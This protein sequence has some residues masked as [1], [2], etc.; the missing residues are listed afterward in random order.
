MAGTLFFL[1]QTNITPMHTHTLAKTVPTPAHMHAHVPVALPS[2]SVTYKSAVN[3]Y[4]S[5]LGRGTRDRLFY[6]HLKYISWLMKVSYE[7]AVA[8]FLKTP[9]ATRKSNKAQVCH[10][11]YLIFLVCHLG[12]YCIGQTIC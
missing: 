12:S 2:V 11:Q 9:G 3:R 1:S 5:V 8:Q 6:G 4:V 10:E 7:A